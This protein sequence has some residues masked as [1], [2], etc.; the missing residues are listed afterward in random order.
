MYF[1]QNLYLFQSQKWISENH[2]F[3]VTTITLSEVIVLIPAHYDDILL[4]ITSA[5]TSLIYTYQLA[6][7]SY[8]NTL[9]A[10]F[11]WLVKNS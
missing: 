2:I 3:K 8:Y 6:W 10:L 5:Q 7:V 1:Q 4:A 11:I 9:L